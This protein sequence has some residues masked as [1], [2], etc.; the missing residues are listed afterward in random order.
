MHKNQIFVDQFE[1]HTSECRSLKRYTAVVIPFGAVWRNH[2]YNDGIKL[3]DLNNIAFNNR[4]AAL[5]SEKFVH[6]L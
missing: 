3:A 1:T 6:K 4:L 5:V 2:A